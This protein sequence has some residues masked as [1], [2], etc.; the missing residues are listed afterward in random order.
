MPIP[1]AVVKPITFTSVYSSA[2]YSSKTA[3]R[4]SVASCRAFRLAGRN[5]QHGLG[6]QRRRVGGN[7]KGDVRNPFNR[8][9]VLLHRTGAELTRRK[10][11]HGQRAAGALFQLL[12]EPLEH[13]R[14]G[15]VLRRHECRDG[16]LFAGCRLRGK[17]KRRC[18]R[19]NQTET[20]VSH[21]I[22]PRLAQQTSA[23]LGSQTLIAVACTDRLSSDRPQETPITGS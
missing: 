21:C 5:R 16:Q 14:V 22:L 17:S 19:Q 8:T 18:E 7:T 9:L 23:P 12:A 15:V 2:R 11:L 10:Q 13:H 20:S 4:R 3:R 6:K 1:A